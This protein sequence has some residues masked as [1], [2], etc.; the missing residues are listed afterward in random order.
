MRPSINHAA[1]ARFKIIWLLLLASAELNGQ[2]LL[3]EG[4]D[5]IR[6]DSI[7][8]HYRYGFSSGASPRLIETDSAIEYISESSSV[9]F[10]WDFRGVI[11]KEHRLYDRQ[12][13]EI[14]LIRSTCVSGAFS[15]K[16]IHSPGSKLTLILAAADQ[17]YVI[18]KTSYEYQSFRSDSGELI[19][20]HLFEHPWYGSDS[21]NLRN[22]LLLSFDNES[23]IVRE[24]LIGP[25]RDT[26]YHSINYYHGTSVNFDS[27]MYQEWHYNSDTK[28]REPGRRWISYPIHAQVDSCVNVFMRGLGSR[29]H[30]DR[31]A[32]SGLLEQLSCGD[33]FG[34]NYHYKYRFKDEGEIEIEIEPTPTFVV[35]APSG[36]VTLRII[37]PALD[38]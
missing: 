15:L 16:E 30:V 3:I 4:H 33:C 7:A 20:R 26:S 22:T 9:I 37:R 8:R 24:V 5:T 25:E 23:R 28:K 27:S 19:I 6:V 10:T 18:G 29:L 2:A 35:Q 21:G 32:Y 1:R 17:W 38:W 13:R 36:W 12:G 11:N 14:S 34:F 31:G